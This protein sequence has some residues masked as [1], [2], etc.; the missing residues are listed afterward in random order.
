VVDPGG[1]NS[2]SIILSPPGA[3]D[4]KGFAAT[5]AGSTLEPTSGDSYISNGL[6]ALTVSPTGKGKDVGTTTDTV[7]CCGGFATGVG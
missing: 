5:A 1:F 4:K 7:P 6:V 2:A 3:C